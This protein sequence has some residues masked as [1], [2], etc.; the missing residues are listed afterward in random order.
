[1][2]F[3]EA[4]QFTETLY[5]AIKKGGEF[6][7]NGAEH[8]QMLE[9]CKLTRVPFKKCTCKFSDRLRDTLTELMLFFKKNTAF[10]TTQYEVL[11]GIAFVVDGIAYTHSNMTDK[12]AETL[13]KER[14]VASKYISKLE[15]EQ[16]DEETTV[17]VTE[18]VK[19]EP[20][21]KTKKRKR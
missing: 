6:E 5:N 17:E 13:L 9:V 15:V 18:E 4:K 2:K 20:V 3:E 7:E 11:R 8:R 10:P 1:M 21:L 12:V 19:T 14:P 16:E